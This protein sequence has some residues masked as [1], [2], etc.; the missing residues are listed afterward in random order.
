MVP[1]LLPLF[2]EKSNSPAMIRHGMNVVKKTA[3]FPND[4]QIFAMAADQPVFALA[5]FVQW[6][7]PAT[8]GEEK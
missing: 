2:Y 8:D 7:W 1:P 4:R 5:K 3:K 6:K